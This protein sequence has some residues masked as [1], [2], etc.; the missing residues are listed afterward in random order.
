[1]CHFL[2]HAFALSMTVARPSLSIDRP[3]VDNR[4]GETL[5]GLRR[6]R[7]RQQSYSCSDPA[8]RDPADSHNILTTAGVSCSRMF[9]LLNVCCIQMHSLA[10]YM[11]TYLEFGRQRDPPP[12]PSSVPLSWRCQHWQVQRQE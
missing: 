10:N 6:L 2:A 8:G 9:Q 3:V 11:L 5:S 4:G 7:N 12:L 1:M